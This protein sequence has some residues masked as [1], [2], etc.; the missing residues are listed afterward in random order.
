M[1]LPM[2]RR[3]GETGFEAPITQLVEQLC[4]STETHGFA[5]LDHC[6]LFTEL[7]RRKGMN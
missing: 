2:A 4:A 1:G 7:A 3:W 5:D 6:G